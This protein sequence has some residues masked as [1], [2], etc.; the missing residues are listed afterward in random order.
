MH[1]RRSVLIRL[2]FCFVTEIIDRLV[3]NTLI[4][5]DER[6]INLITLRGVPSHL[7]ETARRC[8]A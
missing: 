8:L 1:E 2:L 4:N 7:L 3:I 5:V 6:R